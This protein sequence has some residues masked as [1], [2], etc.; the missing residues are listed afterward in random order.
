MGCKGGFKSEDTGEFLLLLNKYSKFTIL[1]RK[2]EYL[3]C[4]LRLSLFWL[5][6]TFSFLID[7]LADSKRTFSYII[8]WITIKIRLG[9]ATPTL[10]RNFLND[11]DPSLASIIVQLRVLQSKPCLPQAPVKDGYGRVFL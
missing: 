6:S 5:K 11:K 2:F 3:S 10:I 8:R 1:S 7:F 9:N 4:L